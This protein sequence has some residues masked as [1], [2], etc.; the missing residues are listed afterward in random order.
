MLKEVVFRHTYVAI[1][2]WGKSYLTSHLENQAVK[3]VFVSSLKSGS[4][5]IHIIIAKSQWSK[6]YLTSCLENQA[7]KLIF[8]SSLKS[9][10]TYIRSCKIVIINM[11]CC[12]IFKKLSNL[13]VFNLFDHA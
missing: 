10:S 13:L 9:G 4:T 6:S 1:S 3:L 2:Q 7:V 11:H 8:G 5:Y 12:S